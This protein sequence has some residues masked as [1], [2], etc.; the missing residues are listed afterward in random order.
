LDP[1][2][3]PGISKVRRVVRRSKTT[4]FVFNRDSYCSSTSADPNKT[5]DCVSQAHQSCSKLVRLTSRKTPLTD[6]RKHNRQKYVAATR[7]RREPRFALSRP[8]CDMH[9]RHNN[10]IKMTTTRN[11]KKAKAATQT[12]RRP[13]L[14]IRSFSRNV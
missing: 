3:P 7:N 6:A 13:S 4:M 1:G 8:R 11:T 14:T 2:D 9:Q 10:S 12:R 5:G